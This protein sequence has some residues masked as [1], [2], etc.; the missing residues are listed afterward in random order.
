M[1]GSILDGRCLLAEITV[2][3][4]ETMDSDA[5]E[6]EV[7]TLADISSLDGCAMW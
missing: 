1:L 5:N 4:H 7:L 6:Q 2:A 3:Q